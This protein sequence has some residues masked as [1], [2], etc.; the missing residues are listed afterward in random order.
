MNIGDWAIGR[1]DSVPCRV[2]SW[3]WGSC[4][5]HSPGLTQPVVRLL[6]LTYSGQRRALSAETKT[7]GLGGLD[8]EMCSFSVLELEV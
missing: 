8:T 2:Q 1:G 7:H 4:S 5:Y 6:P 3:G